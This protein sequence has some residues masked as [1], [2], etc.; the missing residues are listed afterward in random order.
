M[1]YNLL[2]VGYLFFLIEYYYMN[3]SVFPA[4]VGYI[5]IYAG[6]SALLKKENNRYYLAAKKF[7]LTLIILSVLFLYHPVASGKYLLTNLGAE[8]G[9]FFVFVRWGAF[10]VMVIFHFFVIYY[11]TTGI[12]KRAATFDADSLE[13]KAYRR[14]EWYKLFICGIVLSNFVYFIGIYVSGLILPML[15]ILF[16]FYC[17]VHISFLMLIKQASREIRIP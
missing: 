16:V 9:C 3:I 2:F 1:G 12:A 15:V 14:W 7:S 17:I 8:F 13:K 6:L 4:F 11:I 10:L 5:L